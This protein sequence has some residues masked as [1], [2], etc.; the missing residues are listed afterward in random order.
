[1]PRPVERVVHDLGDS[2][3]DASS[4]VSELRIEDGREQRVTETK[5]VVFAFDHVRDNGRIQR[6]RVDAGPLEQRGRGSP[7]CGCE[8]ERLARRRGKAGEARTQE[9][10]ERLRDGK[11]LCRVDLEAQGAPELER[12]ERIA[13][14]ALVDPEQ[15]LTRKGPIHSVAQKPVQ[16][17]DAQR[18]ERQPLDVLLCERLLDLRRLCAACAAP[19][20][21]KA[22]A[23]CIEPPQTRRRARRS[24]PRRTTADRRSRRQACAPPRAPRARRERRALAHANRRYPASCPRPGALLRA[25]AD[26]AATTEAARR[27]GHARTDRRSRRTRG[28]APP[29]PVARKGQAVPAHA[30]TRPPRAR[31]PTSRFRALPGARARKGPAPRCR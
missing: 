27:R 1:M 28:C 3:V 31:A 4:F 17:A 30:R 9:P 21:E 11:R 22:H 8:S 2:P 6:V 29:R 14:R 12:V 16:R 18:P 23:A 10:L 15:R 7:E 19:C 13:A 5:R 26:A 20:K 25:H 24:R